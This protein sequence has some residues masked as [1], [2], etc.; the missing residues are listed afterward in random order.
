MGRLAD[1][2]QRLWEPLLRAEPVYIETMFETVDARHGSTEAYVSEILGV[3]SADI[4]AIRD[5]LLI[6]AD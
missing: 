3:D 4:E 6:P 1:Y 2:D 5:A